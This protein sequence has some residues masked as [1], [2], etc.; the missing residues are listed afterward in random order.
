MRHILA[1][2]WCVALGCGGSGDDMEPESPVAPPV[3]RECPVFPLGT[4]SIDGRQYEPV[5]SNISVRETYRG[6]NGEF[7]D[8]CIGGTLIQHACDVNHIEGPPGDPITWTSASGNVETLIVEC[9]RPCRD[10]ACPNVCPAID[11]ELR[12]LWIDTAGNARF[13]SLATGNKYT[14][15]L[16]SSANSADCTTAPKPDDVVN[17]IS[18]RDCFTGI[19]FS[20]GTGVAPEC[21][22]SS[23]TLVVP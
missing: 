13:E 4:P 18:T 11:E 6:E 17:V 16:Q 5:P 8:Y 3:Q 10:G 12:Y 20:T 2:I 22:Y 19:D 9:F 15:L 14:C 1:Q 21:N 23:C 7:T